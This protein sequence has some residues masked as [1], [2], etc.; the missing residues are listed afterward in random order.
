MAFRSPSGYAALRPA[1]LRTGDPAG[2]SG[3]QTSAKDRSVNAEP[4]PELRIQPATR[5]DVPVI[6]RLTRGIAEYERLAHEVVATEEILLESLFGP[7]PA[8]EVLIG[9]VGDEPVGFAVYFQNFST[10]LGRPG[11]YLEDVFIVPEHRRHGFGRR[12]MKRVARIAV[13]RGCRR[14]EWSVLD[15]NEPALN[16]YDRIGARRMN[17]WVSYRLAGDA[18]RRF[19]ME[20]SA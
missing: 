16:L 13:E 15:W 9:Y 6:L 11:L 1:R 8:A 19:A 5:E 10:F 18:L 2:P 7:R 4:T 3:R 17:E 20:E 14:M 12:L